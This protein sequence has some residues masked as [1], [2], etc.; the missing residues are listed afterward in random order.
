MSVT[1]PVAELL[2]DLPEA[3]LKKGDELR[4]MANVGRLDEWVVLNRLYDGFVPTALSS[5]SPGRIAFCVK[6]AQLKFPPP[7]VPK[8]PV[9]VADPPGK[10]RPRLRPRRKR[11]QQP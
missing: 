10:L 8:P 6:T 11:G 3:G 9:A 4:V 2:V 5:V 7:P 1:N